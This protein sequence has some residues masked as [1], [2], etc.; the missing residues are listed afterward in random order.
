MPGR[1]QGEFLLFCRE[2]DP[3]METWHG[4]RAGLEGAC[5]QYGA[6][7]AFPI[8]DLDDILPGLLENR[9]SVYY[10]MGYYPE[11]DAQVIGWVNS[12]RRRARNGASA[13]AEFI[14]LD[15]L[16]HDMRVVKSRAEI[17]VM[18]KAAAISALAHK[19][20]MRK[21]KPGRNEY[22]IEA[23]LQYEF[24]RGGSRFPAY[25]SIVAGGRNACTLHYT[26]NDDALKDGD[27]L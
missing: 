25:P 15:H 14:A 3:E 27:L 7:D 9:G 1:K 20:A 5:E 6:D 21:T 2:K 11:L 12:V 26:E 8:D 24:G 13:P 22:E 4:F 18:R 17:G 19:R 23:E 16:L 10:A